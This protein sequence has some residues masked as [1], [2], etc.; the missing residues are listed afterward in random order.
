[1]LLDYLQKL[2]QDPSNNRYGCGE[3][4]DSALQQQELQA[5]MF[6]TDFWFIWTFLFLT[7]MFSRLKRNVV[8]IITSS[9]WFDT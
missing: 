7:Y 8:D 9:V 5:T 2:G 6:N 1:M 3:I 4:F